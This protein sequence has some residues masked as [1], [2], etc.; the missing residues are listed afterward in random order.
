[1][2][3]KQTLPLARVESIVPPLAHATEIV[4]ARDTT[5]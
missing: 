1:M 5:L 3:F 4:I 2:D